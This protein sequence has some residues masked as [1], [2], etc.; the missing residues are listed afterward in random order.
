MA[1][2][3]ANTFAHA[4]LKQAEGLDFDHKV[5]IGI[6]NSR[7]DAQL[8]QVMFALRLSGRVHAMDTQFSRAHQEET[9]VHLA[10]P[11]DDRRH[12]G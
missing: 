4:F 12:R 3:R 11:H 9:E 5:I 6:R 1:S 8:P 7:F 10:R 2:S